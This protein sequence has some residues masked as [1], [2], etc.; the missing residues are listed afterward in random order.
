MKK[1][2]LISLI[3]LS[4]ITIA[5]D[6]LILQP[7][8]EGKD[9]QINDYYTENLGD[10]TNLFAIA[11]THSG[12]PFVSR[13][14]IEFDLSVF[15]DSVFI[16]EARLSLFFANNEATPQTH[17]GDNEALLQRVTE[18]WDEHTVTWYNQ[19]QVTQENQVILP[20]STDPEQDYTD[21]DV[22]SLI[23]SI[24]DDPENSHGLLFRL[25]TE[26]MYRRMMFASGDYEIPELWPRL[27]V[28]YEDC[29][30]PVSSFNYSKDELDIHFQDSSMLAEDYYWDFG[31]GY[32]SSLINPWHQYQA[33]GSYEVCLTTWNSCWSNTYCEWIEVC[34][35][36]QAAFTFVIDGMTAWF[37]NQSVKA[38]SYY[39]DFGDGYYSDLTDP[40]HIY[41]TPEN[42]Q[43][44]LKA[45]NDC[46]ADTLCN[47]L[48]LASVSI[49]E[50]EPASF[51]IFPNPANDKVFLKTTLS[52]KVNISILDLSGK[53]VTDMVADANSGETIELNLKAF[54][55]GIYLVMAESGSG[56]YY[57]KLAVS[58]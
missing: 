21:I 32:Y 10:Y 56:R 9:A 3:L 5:Q 23:Q 51:V 49:S 30:P 55:P 54:A 44:C 37:E 19:P 53:T 35:S 27:L 33:E 58:K 26:E 31:D 42:F 15:S 4:Q 11:G 2:L 41:D 24:C 29:N 25:E 8:P 48:Y 13:S 7:G 38:E 12:T 52:G 50:N 14:L 17:Y 22:T 16:I 6:T 1:L 34:E 45:F 46:G 39:W 40:M 20:A 36:P 18:P 43:V 57:K 28:I 47:M